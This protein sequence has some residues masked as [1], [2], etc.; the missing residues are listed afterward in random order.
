V[1]IVCW[2][3]GEQWE[4]TSHRSTMSR[5]VGVST[6]HNAWKSCCCRAAELLAANPSG[7]RFDGGQFSRELAC[8]SLDSLSVTKGALPSAQRTL[9]A[10]TVDRCELTILQQLCV[11]QSLGR[12]L[13]RKSVS[14]NQHI[15]SQAQDHAVTRLES[16][17]MAEPQRINW[18]HSRKYAAASCLA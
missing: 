7:S 10:Q 8:C 14:A 3:S 9:A 12:T 6:E 11:H 4:L 17:Q 13:E 1:G 16:R 2:C 15:Y 18:V 5:G